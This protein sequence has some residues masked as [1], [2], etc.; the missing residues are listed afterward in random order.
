MGRVRWIPVFFGAMVY[1]QVPPAPEPGE[2]ACIQT[3][4]TVAMPL[5]GLPPSTTVSSTP[6]PFGNLVLDG[7]GKYRMT[8]GRGNSGAYRY[9]GATGQVTF[10]GVL[11]RTQSSY[12]TR[13][14][15]LYFEFRTQ[16]VSFSCSRNGK[17]DHGERRGSSPEHHS[18]P[19]AS[20]NSRF[21]GRLYYA[22]HRGAFRVDLQT[23]Q[24]KAIGLSGNFDV[25]ADGRVVYVDSHGEMILTNEDG[26]GRTRVPVYGS[27]NYSPRF[28]PD[29]SRIAYHGGQKPQGMEAAL[30]SA[31]SNKRLEPLVVS[32]DG[33]L[34]AAFGSDYAQPC[35]TPD[36]RI[37]M[38]G[39]KA[40]PGITSGNQ[41]GLFISDPQLRRLTRLPLDF[42]APH[43]PAVSPDGTKLAFANGPALWVSAIDGSAPRK[44]Y[45]GASRHVMFPAWSPDGQALA[46]VDNQVVGIVSLKGEEIPVKTS[47]G[48]VVR[49]TAEVLWLR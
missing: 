19:A 38:A 9:D 6:A 40:A 17:T 1:A 21:A 11:G 45:E 8:L 31:F 23:G 22:D 5:P 32:A 26:S 42:D 39:A 48:A 20:P 35:W 12:A 24:E 47:N 29:G 3:N 15:L 49:S 7:A 18:T 25:R 10:D 27:K 43:S 36:G 34:H 2:Y 4:L 44:V 41:A 37:V 13:G 16:V 33:R 14:K 28:S 30:E 46:F